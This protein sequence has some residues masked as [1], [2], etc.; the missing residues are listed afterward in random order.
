MEHP[1]EPT[2][3]YPP[4]FRHNQ[5]LVLS[6]S[7]HRN[8]SMDHDFQ[9]GLP[10]TRGVGTTY[11]TTSMVYT[12]E[13]DATAFTAPGP[14]TVLPTSAQHLSIAH[15]QGNSGHD[16]VPQDVVAPSL[17]CEVSTHKHPAG[18]DARSQGSCQRNVTFQPT[19]PSSYTR[20]SLY[21]DAHLTAGAVPPR[22]YA[23]VPTMPVKEDQRQEEEE[24]EGASFGTSQSAPP[25]VVG[26][27]ARGQ[28]I[29]PGP[30]VPPEPVPPPSNRM[31]ETPVPLPRVKSP[32][33]HLPYPED[34]AA[35]AAAATTTTNTG[36]D[37]PQHSLPEGQQQSPS[38]VST[39]APLSPVVL[40]P[41]LT[42]IQ[43]SGTETHS[44]CDGHAGGGGVESDDLAENDEPHPSPSSQ[45]RGRRGKKQPKKV[46]FL[47]CFFCRERKIA[48]H[49][50]N[51]GDEDR[52][53]T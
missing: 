5:V 4:S 28:Y 3:Y 15:H 18:D 31:A 6:P 19:D 30:V 2:M 51:D 12:E 40:A 7:E 36:D 32:M 35:A 20:T 34:I 45:R 16:H 8:V 48:C 26:T 10:S 37:K 53:C 43:Y 41:A 49:P 14:A 39:A 21:Q 33:A 1:E 42:F 27:A 50:K 24:E 17:S 44:H 46:V 25:Q 29:A 23:P 52:T 22:G 13:P 11:G 47:A 9:A 38:P